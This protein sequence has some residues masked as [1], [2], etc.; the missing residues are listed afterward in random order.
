MLEDRSNIDELFR[1]GLSDFGE[2]MPKHIWNNIDEELAGDKKKKR[3]F[4]YWSVAASVA[5]ILSFGSGYMLNWFSY[6]ND[7]AELKAAQEELRNMAINII[8]TEA[9]NSNE[10]RN[11]TPE[12]T[13]SSEDKIEKEK[14]E[15]I[16]ASDVQPLERKPDRVLQHVNNNPS[17]DKSSGQQFIAGSKNSNNTTKPNEVGSIAE[18]S[19]K[20]PLLA[21]ESE[22]IVNPFEV[23]GIETIMANKI[24]IKTIKSEEIFKENNPLENLSDEEL[25]NLLIQPDDPANEQE[26]YAANDQPQSSGWSIGGQFVPS[27]SPSSQ[28]AN[29]GALQQDSYA[30]ATE[31]KSKREEAKADD[32]IM[33]STGI[34]VQYNIKEKI[35]LQSGF[36]FSKFSNTYEHIEVPAL[37]NY[38]VVDSKVRL[39]VSAGGAAGYMVSQGVGGFNPIDISALAGFGFGI[40]VNDRV[41]ISAQ[42][43][44]KYHIPATRNYFIDNAPVSYTLLTGITYNL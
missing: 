8:N 19:S 40:K 35:G 3:T 38:T 15:E 42:P 11:S 28:V 4:I 43:A 37:I 31:Y 30:V 5:I 26:L 20:E 21:E 36:Y 2:D 22:P 6:K 25:R 18:P 16:E 14:Q 39:F 27:F 29:E 12:N 44:L 9:V 13:V 24:E 10:S 34:G 17:V 33:F 1:N 7:I 41:S 32:R 23:Q